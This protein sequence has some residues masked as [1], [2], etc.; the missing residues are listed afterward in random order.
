MQKSPKVATLEVM[1]KATHHQRGAGC[2]TTPEIRSVNQLK[3]R[4]C[5]T[6]GT[7]VMCCSAASTVSGAAGAP[8]I[9]YE[10]SI[11]GLRRHKM[12]MFLWFIPAISPQNLR[13]QYFPRRASSGLDCECAPDN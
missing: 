3:L 1:A 4:R 11:R 8:S 7:R 2:S 10:K 5:R 6:S 9:L 13:P 12:V